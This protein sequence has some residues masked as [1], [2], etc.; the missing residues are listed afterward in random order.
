MSIDYCHSHHHLFDTD[1]WSGCPEC[2][3]SPIT[4]IP[5]EFSGAPP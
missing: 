2:S 5:Y 4:I 1:K 3:S